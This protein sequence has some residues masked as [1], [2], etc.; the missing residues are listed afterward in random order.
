MTIT[1]TRLETRLREAEK[2]LQRLEKRLA[3]KPEFGRGDG[4]TNPSSRERAFARKERIIVEI[5]ELQKALTRMQEG[6]YDRC[7]QCGT[8]IDPERLEIL[9]T[10]TLCI[11]CAQAIGPIPGWG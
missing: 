8:Q 6:V 7:E 4:S 2:K 1:K 5:H 3:Q 9:P 11:T 10:T